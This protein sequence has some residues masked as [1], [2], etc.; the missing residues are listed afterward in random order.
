MPHIS[1]ANVPLLLADPGHEL[2]RWLDLNLPLMD[3]ELVGTLDSWYREGRERSR[4]ANLPRSNG[5][6][7][8][9]VTL[10]VPNY[11]SCRPPRWKINSLW[12]PTGAARHSIGLFLASDAELTQI[13]ANLQQSSNSYGSAGQL[14]I[15]EGSGSTPDESSP[16]RLVVDQMYL[17]PPMRLTNV[18]G[19]SQVLWLLM[20][21]DQRYFWHQATTG[22]FEITSEFGGGTTWEELYDTLGT[23]LGTTI[24]Y[25]DI[26]AAYGTPDPVE[27]GR[28][29]E[30]PAMMLDAI[31]ASLGQR[32]VFG[33]DSSVGALNYFSSED[34]F[35]A[36][37]A[38]HRAFSAG[39]TPADWRFTAYPESVRV[40]FPIRNFYQLTVEKSRNVD[41]TYQ[42]LFGSGQDTTS[43]SFKTFYS[44]ALADYSSD[45]ATTS[46]E[47]Y[48]TN[49]PANLTDMEDLADI[50]ADDFYGYIS[51]PYDV[52]FPGVFKWIPE[53]FND[54]VWY[55]AGSQR[56]TE[57]DGEG[58]YDYYTRAC[59]QHT[60]FGV[61]SQL[62]QLLGPVRALNL[63]ACGD[64]SIAMRVFNTRDYAAG[65][66]LSAHIG[67]VARVF[68]K[69][70]EIT[71]LAAT[72]ADAIRAP[73]ASIQATCEGCDSATPGSS[74]TT[75]VRF[76]ITE[77]KPRTTVA[78]KAV[79][80]D[81]VTGEPEGGSASFWTA[82]TPV[83]AGERRRATAAVG[84]FTYG[85]VIVSNSARTT[86]ATFDATEAGFWT[87]ANEQI[88]VVD[89]DLK[90]TGYVHYDDPEYG[91][92]ASYRGFA[93][94]FIENYSGTG[95]PGYAIL[96]M[97]GEARFI[98]CVLLEDKAAAATTVKAKVNF[99]YG[100]PPNGRAPRTTS[101]EI[102]SSYPEGP[103]GT[104]GVVTLTD[105][106]D[107]GFLPA[108][109]TVRAELDERSGV[110]VMQTT[111][112][113]VLIRGK[114]TAAVTTSSPFTIDEVTAIIGRSPVNSIDDTVTVTNVP[115][116]RF[117]DNDFVYAL[118]DPTLAG[119]NY[120]AMWRVAIEYDLE[121]ILHGFPDFASG[122]RQQLIHDATANDPVKWASYNIDIVRFV[123]NQP[124][125]IGQ[126][127]VVATIISSTAGATGLINV[128]SPDGR[129]AGLTNWK[130]YAYS[131]GTV[132]HIISLD[133]PARF[134]DFTALS[135]SPPA[136][137]TITC[138]VV[139]FWGNPPNSELIVGT[140]VIVHKLAS[141]A[142][143]VAG[144]DPLRAI[145]DEK[146]GRWELFW[147][148]GLFITVRGTVTS[149]ITSSDPTFTI[150][151]PALVNGLKLPTGPLL[152]TNN[153]PL[154]TSGSTVVYARYNYDANGWDTGD[155]GNFLTKLKGIGSYNGGGEPQLVAQEAEDNPEWVTPD[156]YDEDVEQVL[157]HDIDEP[158]LFKWLAG[159]TRMDVAQI[160]GTVPGHGS[161]GTA[162]TFG[163]DSFVCYNPSG[164][165]FV[166]GAT[167]TVLGAI[168]A[169]DGET[170]FVLP[171]VDP[172]S[173]P[174]WVTGND[175]SVGHDAGA[176]EEWQDDEACS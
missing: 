12:W 79:V 128:T 66:L 135:D 168:L 29:Y 48:A 1:Y 60:T 164:V 30:D 9:N 3:R 76:E 130:G 52:T 2:Q 14:I 39:G 114:A 41:V 97:E 108:G 70:F 69:C 20:L 46:T 78:V 126:T 100:L 140:S 149:P 157:G 123:L 34:I 22:N 137:A 163:G 93:Y 24:I 124:I 115:K 129:F 50:I 59:S 44:T 176:L 153:P 104:I 113:F 72:T 132:Y 151:T 150:T 77:D 81:E 45:D 152:V 87:S 49:D 53:G 162:N 83:T 92:T 106:L 56:D 105:Y 125:T 131:D 118:F 111:P 86:G 62:S 171:T 7:V 40:V 18:S 167:I 165:A 10:P 64:T 107:Q 26:P 134:A 51:A 174:G 173:R 36:N 32:I 141:E 136:S 57:R 96:E 144:G 75:V 116:A 117:A 101:Q 31:A 80:I 11:S 119:V 42:S 84:G 25:D 91:V 103:T 121:A 98:D 156:D 112:P 82:A 35:Q 54:W 147:Y 27:V 15:D 43:G 85:Q 148:G 38:Q 146:L 161:G 143:N 58:D 99:F 21:V 145:W 37:E 28:L 63:T 16:H 158:R 8:P 138:D 170:L 154:E 160:S 89:P 68:G 159:Y 74:T 110:Y 169:I 127:T 175:Q 19:S 47:E 139:K 17:L 166:G 71:A 6:A 122:T 55:H 65:E 94:K 67:E 142:I 13:L 95:D 5:F 120:R 109:T 61:T 172:K 133:G 90:Y 102:T 155:G 33:Y 73:V 88:R 23:R 4:G